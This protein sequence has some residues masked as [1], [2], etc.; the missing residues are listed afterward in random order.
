MRSSTGAELR[1]FEGL[2]YSTARMFAA[3]VRREEEDLAQELRVR[4]WRAAVTYDPA[5]SRLSLERYVFQAV[6][7][8]IKD[9]KRDAAREA[10]R[11][12]ENGLVFL[13]IEDMPNYSSLLEDTRPLNTPTQEAFDGHFH[14]ADHD[15]VYGRIDE[16]LFVLPATITEN[17]VTV[18]LLLLVGLSRSEVVS[19]LPLW[20]RSDVDRAIAGLRQKLADWKPTDASQVVELVGVA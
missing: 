11:R 3:Q 1:A 20:P 12:E 7:N 13:H 10:R 5:K 18:L 16:G 15:E 14:F 17:E 2:V 19:S 6:T 4:V 8:K 9:F